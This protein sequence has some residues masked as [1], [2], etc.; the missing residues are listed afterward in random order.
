MQRQIPRDGPFHVHL[1]LSHLNL[2]ALGVTGNIGS[3]SECLQ[4]VAAL[5]AALRRLF[6]RLSAKEM[7]CLNYT[8]D[9]EKRDVAVVV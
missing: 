2:A 6:G 7:Q 9:G 3:G 4:S 8:I 1:Q 5:A